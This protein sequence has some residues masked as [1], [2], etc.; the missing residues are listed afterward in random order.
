MQAAHLLIDV[1]KEIIGEI[2]QDEKMMLISKMKEA[3][4]ES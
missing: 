1:K 2:S 4:W 3:R